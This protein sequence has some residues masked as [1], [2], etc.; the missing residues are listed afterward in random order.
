MGKWFN[1]NKKT[2]LRA[3]WDKP[4]YF[5]IGVLM[6]LVTIGIT[7]VF[8]TCY[9]E[10][11]S[12]RNGI[13]QFIWLG[14][15]IGFF[16]WMSNLDLRYFKKYSFW[17]I[18]LCLLMLI[19][20]PFVGTEVN[21]ATRW[22]QLGPIS[23]QPAEFAKIAFVLGLAQMV[24][25]TREF[26]YPAFKSGKVNFEW[27][28]AFG[29]ILAIMLFLIGKE[30]LSAAISFVFLMCLIGFYGNIQKTPFGKFAM[31]LFL[32]VIILAYPLGRMRGI[33]LY[34]KDNPSET[35]L[36]NRQMSEATMLE[37]ALSKQEDARTDM[38][39]YLVN[40][41]ERL[42][43][44]KKIEV[45]EEKENTYASSFSMGKDGEIGWRDKRIA[46]WIN[47][48]QYIN[49]IGLQ[50]AYGLLAIST[51]GIF[52]N[53]LGEGICKFNIPE[54]HND[55]IFPSIIEET[56][57]LGG[58]IIIALYIC[59]FVRAFSIMEKC[60]SK[61][62]KLLACGALIVLATE[63]FINL[64]VALNIIPSTGVCLP[65]ISYGGSSTIVN[66][67]CA[68][69]IIG[70]SKQINVPDKIISNYTQKIYPRGTKFTP[71][72]FSLK[73]P[74]NMEKKIKN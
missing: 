61:Y 50:P 72:P 20:L 60:N 44:G 74:V 48:K 23:I 57:F 65:F 49:D 29:V 2:N 40:N 9:S 43:L 64:M 58:L 1:Y 33:N 39:K 56:G 36:M 21:G 53:G 19:A 51:G 34:N 16:F 35:E 47:P 27:F 3:K 41:Y 11:A 7:F 38:E 32:L 14:V 28:W 10:K 15:G 12:F 45:D 63:V 42:N 68:G 59:L 5:F 31:I 30:S 26:E 67:I 25:W 13:M 54:S 6:V 73:M 4:D 37:N 62:G 69:I 46:A 66:F 55:Y 71:I 17:Y 24:D 18:L 52:G 70:V 8:D 22:I